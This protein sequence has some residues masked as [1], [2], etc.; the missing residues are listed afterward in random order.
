MSSPEISAAASDSYVKAVRRLSEGSV[1]K[2]KKNG[3]FCCA[4]ANSKN[5]DTKRIEKVAHASIEKI[6]A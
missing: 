4:K 6:G 3:C 1:Q 5:K 2:K